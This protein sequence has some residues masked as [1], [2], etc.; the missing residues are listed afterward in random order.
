[1]SRDVDIFHD[2]DEALAA[3]WRADRVLLEAN[4]FS[5]VVMRER[6]T[7]VEAE[8][9]AATDRVRLEWARD[10]AFRFFPLEQH[11]EFGLTL[12]PFDLARTRCSP[13]S[14]A[15]RCATGST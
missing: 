15:W 11:E 14:D 9:R 13:S 3:S 8:I 6:P 7:L 1:I 10:S 12:H 4:G 2:T 5:V